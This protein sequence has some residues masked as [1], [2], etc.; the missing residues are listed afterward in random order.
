ML[1]SDRIPERVQ[2]YPTTKSFI[3]VLDALQEFKTELIAKA[4]RVNNIAILTDKEWLLKRLAEIGVE[5]FPR[6][7]PIGI[8]QQYLLNADTVFGTKG[9]KIGV[10]LYCSLLSLGE[11][12][13][14][15]NEF[16]APS[17]ILIL[18]SKVQGHI[19][20]D[21]TSNV[22]SLCEDN[23][24][25]WQ[26]VSLKVHIKSKYFDGNHIKEERVIKDYLRKTLSDH[27]GFSPEKNITFTYQPREEF[28][29]HKL[30]NSYFI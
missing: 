22:Y 16:Y 26:A 9:S 5:G 14:D 1:L 24:I 11:V 8:M 25:M 7:Y 2:E 18:D 6:D 20:E 4:L 29:Y 13:I 3:E 28:Y 19:I 15:D 10:E 23:D 27:L 30:L 12:T 17:K 21:S